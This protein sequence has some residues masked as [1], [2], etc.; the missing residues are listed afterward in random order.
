MES[1]LACEFLGLARTPGERLGEE[2][3]EGG[4]EGGGWEKAYSSIRSHN[5]CTGASSCKADEIH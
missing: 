1:L 3:E 2:E 5:L 4:G